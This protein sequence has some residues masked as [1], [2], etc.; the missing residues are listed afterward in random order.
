MAREHTPNFIHAL[1]AATQ[2]AALAPEIPAYLG[3]EPG[4]TLSF[5]LWRIELPDSGGENFATGSLLTANVVNFN[6]RPA[7]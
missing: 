1:T 2:H 6:E 3:F 5:F 4:A 7:D